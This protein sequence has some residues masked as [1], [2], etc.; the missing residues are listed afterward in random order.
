M[1]GYSAGEAIEFWDAYLGA[2]PKPGEPR[3]TPPP[4][5][6]LREVTRQPAE[7]HGTEVQDPY[8]YLGP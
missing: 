4:P 6:M 8:P 3:H 1:V 5:E 2:G 7:L